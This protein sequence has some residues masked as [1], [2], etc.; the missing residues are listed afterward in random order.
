VHPK[1][2]KDALFYDFSK[3]TRFSEW[4]PANSYKNLRK[5]RKSRKNEKKRDKKVPVFFTINPLPKCPFFFILRE[6][7]R[8]PEKVTFLRSKIR[9]ICFLKTRVWENDGKRETFCRENH[10][11][12]VCDQTQSQNWRFWQILK[13]SRKTTLQFSACTKYI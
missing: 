1:I 7:L 11:F 2:A 8:K 6:R 12:P 3:K 9:K 10:F 13:K 5:T 4:T